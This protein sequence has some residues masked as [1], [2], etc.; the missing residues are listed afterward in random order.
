LL[1]LRLLNVRL[2]KRKIRSAQQKLNHVC[3]KVARTLRAAVP[4]VNTDILE[5]LA[6]SE[7]FANREIKDTNG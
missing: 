6:R 2:D 1:L 7:A 5:E 3:P 4:D